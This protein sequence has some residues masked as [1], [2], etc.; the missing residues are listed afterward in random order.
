MC[1]HCHKRV[2]N[3]DVQA[4]DDSLGYID[5]LR[6]EMKSFHWRQANIT[7]VDPQSIARTVAGSFPDPAS[8]KNHTALRNTISN[9][10]PRGFSEFIVDVGN[11]VMGRE[12]ACAE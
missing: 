9:P 5:R 3:G 10:P 6:E 7:N 12:A 11:H 1:R 8:I 2:H 4:P